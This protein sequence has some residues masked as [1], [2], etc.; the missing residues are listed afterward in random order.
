M[1]GQRVFSAS[2]PIPCLGGLV[3][4]EM[5]VGLGDYPGIGARQNGTPP[6][7]SR[8]CSV[9]GKLYNWHELGWVAFGHIGA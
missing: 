5:P 3:F 7:R 2:A 8:P 4:A 6:G 1:V 9:C